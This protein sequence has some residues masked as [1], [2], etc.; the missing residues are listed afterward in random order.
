MMAI[1]QDHFTR[2]QEMKQLR[3]MG[4]IGDLTHEEMQKSC[5][6]KGRF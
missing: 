2:R 1:L 5:R 4:A 6:I 3:D